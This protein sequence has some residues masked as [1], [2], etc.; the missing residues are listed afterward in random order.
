MRGKLI[1]SIRRHE[2]LC[3]NEVETG[4]GLVFRHSF[5]NEEIDNLLGDTNTS[6][7]CSKEDGFVLL[8]RN[9]RLFYGIYD[10]S[11]DNSTGSLDVVI[12]A[13]KSMAVPFKSW[14]WVLEI[15]KLND[16]ARP[17]LSQSGHQFV[18]KFQFLL[19]AHLVSTTT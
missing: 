4:L 6:T 14:E 19:W 2:T 15:F 17:F 13:G 7:S 16:N 11:K 3:V 5:A 8:S 18:H 12:E 1:P 10:S 9:A